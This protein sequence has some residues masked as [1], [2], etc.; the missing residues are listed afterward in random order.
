VTLL[1]L[2]GALVVAGIFAYGAFRL[3]TDTTRRRTHTKR[4]N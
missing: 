3:L 1:A 2:I 4:R